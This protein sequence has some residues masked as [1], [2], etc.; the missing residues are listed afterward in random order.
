MVGRV[1]LTGMSTVL[2][3]P[4]SRRSGSKA[5]ERV[6]VDEGAG[7][8]ES[9]E[10]AEKEGACRGDLTAVVTREPSRHAKARLEQHHGDDE[11][12]DG[13][14]E[15]ACERGRGLERGHRPARTCPA[16]A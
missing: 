6:E 12:D 2:L 14:S 3:N 1:R 5:G 11:G 8:D 16:L 15:A 7:L 13:R 10:L 4:P 9:G